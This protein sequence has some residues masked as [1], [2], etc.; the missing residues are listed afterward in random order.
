[1]CSLG[2]RERIQ[3]NQDPCEDREGHKDSRQ[4]QDKWECSFG[5]GKRFVIYRE[6]P[7][8]SSM[9]DMAN[10]STRNAC[11]WISRGIAP[12]MF[13]RWFADWVWLGVQKITR[14]ISASLTT[15]DSP[16]HEVDINWPDA[17]ST[18]MHYPADI[19]IAPDTCTR[20]W[21]IQPPYRDPTIEGS[22]DHCVQSQ[23]T[24]RI[25]GDILSGL[26]GNLEGIY[27]LIPWDEIPTSTSQSQKVILI[28]NRCNSALPTVSWA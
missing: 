10:K 8:S 4:V 13:A 14:S 7:I 18:S 2:Y 17:Y 23:I 25:H 5:I 3:R 22:C 24:I 15:G 11:C 12:C 20:N 19:F 1:M 27:V 26:I 21:G 28:Q 6:G 16:I 9:P